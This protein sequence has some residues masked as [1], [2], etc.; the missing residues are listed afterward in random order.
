KVDFQVGVNSYLYGTRFMTWLA[1][2]YSPE[3]LLA[4]VGRSPGSKRY[5]A[6]QFKQVFGRPL[7]DAWAE[8]IAF[9]HDFQ[10]ANLDTLRLHPTTPSRDLSPLALGSVSRAFV[11]SASHALIAA[12]YRPG[13]VAHIAAIPLDGGPERVLHEVKGP[14]LYFVS[15]L[16]LDA[17]HRQLFFTTDNNEW[18][19]L[20]VLDLA[21]G[22][23]KL[24]IRDAR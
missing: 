23:E 11:D 9:E 21:R 16:A 8:W 2:R 5:F 12:V 3:D 1:Y 20:R 14:A 4:W 6:S 10:R 18:R 7:G 15:S 13:A 24:L 19:D 22:Q 17:A